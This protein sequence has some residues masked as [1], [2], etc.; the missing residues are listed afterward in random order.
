MRAP[1]RT[2]AYRSGRSVAIKA[3]H[4]LQRTFDLPGAACRF[5]IKFGLEVEYMVAF[6]RLHAVIGAVERVEHVR[7]VVADTIASF[8]DGGDRLL[9][10]D[11][12]DGSPA[13]HHGRLGNGAGIGQPFVA[14]VQRRRIA[15]PDASEYQVRVDVPAA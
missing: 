13:G 11:G 7:V 6:Q 5:H 10:S 15:E 9:I 1:R 14:R 8:H 12:P 3:D 2:G 4:R